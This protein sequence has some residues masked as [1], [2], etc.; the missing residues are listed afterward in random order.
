MTCAQG[1][2]HLL[3]GGP[4]VGVLRDCYQEFSNGKNKA[5]EALTVSVTFYLCEALTSCKK[6]KNK[7]F[8]ITKV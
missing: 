5:F 7:Q 2:L 3:W 8:F 4:E 1:L 6:S